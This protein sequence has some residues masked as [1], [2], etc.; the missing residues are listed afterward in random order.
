V[1]GLSVIATITVPRDP[2]DI[3]VTWDGRFAYVTNRFGSPL[4]GDVSAYVSVID[5]SSDTVT[6][7]IPLGV[8]RISAF[9]IALTPDGSRAYVTH[10][11]DASLVVILARILLLP[12]ALL[13]IRSL[14]G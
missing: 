5:T 10:I 4:G 9:G 14:R 8:G 1:D 12:A 6:A 7:S 13:C 2:T 11:D 3:P